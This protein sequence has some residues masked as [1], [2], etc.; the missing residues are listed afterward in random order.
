VINFAQTLGIGDQP[1]DWW[2]HHGPLR[3]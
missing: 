2:R 3:G 1:L